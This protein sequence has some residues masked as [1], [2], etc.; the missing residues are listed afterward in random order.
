[1][2]NDQRKKAI[3]AGKKSAREHRN[4]IAMTNARYEQTAK[5]RKARYPKRKWRLCECGCGREVHILR[6]GFR[7]RL[8]ATQACQFRAFRLRKRKKLPGYCNQC[9]EQFHDP[10]KC[11]ECGGLLKETAPR[12]CRKK[13][14][15]RDI[16]P[17]VKKQGRPRRFCSK[18]CSQKWHFR[19]YTEVGNQFKLNTGARAV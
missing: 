8:Y 19:E 15:G 1:M 7:K 10:R 12:K 2:T 11:A 17:G 4:G 6:P 5:A 14:C 18:A 9:G 13:N 16:M 3:A